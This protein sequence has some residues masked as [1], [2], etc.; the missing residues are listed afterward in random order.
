M[1]IRAHR[2]EK[3][4]WADSSFNL[5]HDEE[6]MG[7]LEKCGFYEKLDLDGCGLAE[8]SVEILQEALE[9]VKKIDNDTK[10]NIRED[11]AQAKRLNEEY[12]TYYCF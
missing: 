10:K 8:I 5:C 7:F 12:L 3:I 1:S 2:V 6:L 9:K 11:I 4:S